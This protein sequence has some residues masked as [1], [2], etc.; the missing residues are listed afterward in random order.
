M[1]S[2]LQLDQA[3]LL[4]ILKTDHQVSTALIIGLEASQRASQSLLKDTTLCLQALKDDQVNRINSEYNSHALL[5]NMKGTN[6]ALHTN[7]HETVNAIKGTSLAVLEQLHQLKD[8]VAQQYLHSQKIEQTVSVI[9]SDLGALVGNAAA[10]EAKM[11]NLKMDMQHAFQSLRKDIS[12]ELQTHKA[13]TTILESTIRSVL[14]E[15]LRHVLSATPSKISSKVPILT[16][17]HT[18][19]RVSDD[20]ADGATEPHESFTIAEAYRSRTQKIYQTRTTRTYRTWI[21]NITIVSIYSSARDSQFESNT[22]VFSIASNIVRVIIQPNASFLKKRISGEI[23]WQRSPFG[24]GSLTVRNLRTWNIVK[25]DSAIVLACEDGD[26]FRVLSLFSTGAASPFDCCEPTLPSSFDCDLACNRSRSLLDIVNDRFGYILIYYSNQMSFDFL[27][28]RSLLNDY[29]KILQL[30][31][32]NGV[33]IGESQGPSGS[34][35][36][37]YSRY[38]DQRIAPSLLPIA[39]QY[40]RLVLKESKADPFFSCN[41]PLRFAFMIWYAQ[42][43]PTEGMVCSVF[44]QQEYWYIE[45]PEPRPS[46]HYT[47]LSF[48][49]GIEYEHVD[50]EPISRDP[51]CQ[52]LRPLF[53]LLMLTNIPSLEHLAESLL[54]LRGEGDLSSVDPNLLPRVETGIRN[55]LALLFER[56]LDPR[57]ILPPYDF[58]NSTFSTLSEYARYQ[59]ALDLWSSALLQSG[60]VEPDVELLLEEDLYVSIAYQLFMLESNEFGWPPKPL[61]YVRIYSEDWLHYLDHYDNLGYL[62]KSSNDD[63]NADS[64]FIV[65]DSDLEKE[66]FDDEYSICPSLGGDDS[67]SEKSYS[68]VSVDIGGKT[69][70]VHNSTELES[71]TLVGGNSWFPSYYFLFKLQGLQYLREARSIY[72]AFTWRLSMTAYTKASDAIVAVMQDYSIV[73]A[74]QKLAALREGEQQRTRHL[75]VAD[76]DPSDL[77]LDGDLTEPIKEDMSSSNLPRFLGHYIEHLG[78]ESGSR[79]CAFSWQ[80]TK[81]RFKAPSMLTFL[82]CTL[83]L[84]SPVK[85]CFICRWHQDRPYTEPPKICFTFSFHRDSGSVQADFSWRGVRIHVEPAPFVYVMINKIN[86]ASKRI[87]SRWTAQFFEDGT[88]R[89]LSDGRVPDGPLGLEFFAQGCCDLGVDD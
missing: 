88:L 47:S 25:E 79:Y 86:L 46:C 53:E 15:E 48:S 7:T 18:V 24:R 59:S 58:F 61:E 13:E 14:G 17:Q 83:Y 71:S 8:C 2:S 72:R 31:I 82:I 56:G 39:V 36:L 62:P 41:L 54:L 11:M 76:V 65:V 75:S 12:T 84:E 26:I 29:L 23:L 4:N 5:A 70:L 27:K 44:L 63:Y 85:R 10:G 78:R 60:W 30:L 21:G 66:S 9:Q 67:E 37:V 77:P 52:S 16:M 57:A 69:V 45:W 3:S 73:R 40:V 1:I 89:P 28:I 38:Y 49:N 81:V 68:Q 51:G 87:W 74:H 33:D 19:D 50:L 42:H 20:L 32:D 64:S 43:A 80:S 6:E 22:E 34:P 35:N 55:R